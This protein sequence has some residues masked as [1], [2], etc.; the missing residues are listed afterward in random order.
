[1]N[2]GLICARTSLACM[3]ICRVRVSTLFIPFY[4][5]CRLVAL[6]FGFV[7]R[8]FM[9]SVCCGY[10]ASA[11]ELNLG[12][13]GAREGACRGRVCLYP[14]LATKAGGISPFDHFPFFYRTFSLP[15]HI[16]ELVSPHEKATFST[17][18][19]KNILAE[20][21]K[22]KSRRADLHFS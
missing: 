4:C 13:F 8:S 20:S 6:F 14:R 10:L 9:T 2:Q 11:S 3:Y 21:R 22:E 16:S 19:P 12:Q 5:R 1:M 7:F 17:W 18:N 15:F